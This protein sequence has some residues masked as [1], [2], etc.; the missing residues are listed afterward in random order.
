MK[1][2]S[3]Q[4]QAETYDQIGQPRMLGPDNG[5]MGEGTDRSHPLCQIISLG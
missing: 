5:Q 3:F 1:P 4:S 2:K